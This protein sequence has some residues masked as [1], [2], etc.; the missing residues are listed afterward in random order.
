[1]FDGWHNKTWMFDEWHNKM[2]MSYC[3][4]NKYALKGVNSSANH[5]LSISSDKF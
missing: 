5:S 4:F 1:M 3:T 2:C